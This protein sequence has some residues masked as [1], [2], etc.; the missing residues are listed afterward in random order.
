MIGAAGAD[1]SGAAGAEAADLYQP[2]APLSVSSA[3][4]Y[5]SASPLRFGHPE[6]HVHEPRRL[7]TLTA[8]IDWGDGSPATVIIA[9]G[10]I[11][12]LLGPARLYRR[13]GCPLSHRRDFD[14]PQWQ[15]GLRPD[16]RR[17]Q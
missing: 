11:V 3:T 9:S 2:G 7:V 14:R 5:A 13:L 8:S 1:G 17:D 6:R 15:V 4:T 16:D 10:R 12:C